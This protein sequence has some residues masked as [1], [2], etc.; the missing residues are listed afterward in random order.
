MIDT[1][2]P[3]GARAAERLGREPIGWLTTVNAEG[4]AQA[5][6]VWFLWED[7]EILVFSRPRVPRMR[8]LRANP[9]VSFNLDSDRPGGHIVTLEGEARV[10]PGAPL[11]HEVPAYLEKYREA[12]AAEGWTPEGMARDYCVTIRI[13]VTRVRTW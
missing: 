11:A 9:R 12:I 2:T 7:G 8:N 3:A 6:P 10:M 1:G 5:S 4:Q 13:R